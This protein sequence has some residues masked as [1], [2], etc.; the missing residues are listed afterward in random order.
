MSQS[1]PKETV[2]ETSSPGE[3]RGTTSTG[4]TGETELL[5]EVT[6]LLIG[7]FVALKPEQWLRRGQRKQCRRLQFPS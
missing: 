5:S 4:A 6:T 1:D 2:N 3:Q 7:V